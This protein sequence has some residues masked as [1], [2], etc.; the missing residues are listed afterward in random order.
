MTRSSGTMYTDIDRQTRTHTD[1]RR[2]GWTEGER[3]M[4][5]NRNTDRKMDEWMDGWMDGRT[6]RE[7]IYIYI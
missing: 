3:Y 7:N 1:R 2:D 5:T 4:E 6:G